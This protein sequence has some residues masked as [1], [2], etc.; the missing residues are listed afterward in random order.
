MATIGG[1]MKVEMV[2]QWQEGN[3]GNEDVG[4]LRRALN[5][6]VESRASGCLG[7]L[8]T[9]NS[10]NGLGLEIP[11]NKRAGICGSLEHTEDLE[12]L[13]L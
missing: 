3:G 1:R 5:T 10:Y 4:S 13:L 2:M 6:L 9:I 8:M 11:T 7:H 12:K